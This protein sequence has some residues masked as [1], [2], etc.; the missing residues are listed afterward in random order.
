VKA[1]IW[2]HGRVCRILVYDA[3]GRLVASNDDWNNIASGQAAVNEAYPEAFQCVY[4]DDT[5]ALDREWDQVTKG[6][7]DAVT[8][9]SR[10]RDGFSEHACG[11][12]LR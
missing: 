10:E 4:R 1:K 9:P 7:T 8:T 3:E 2:I 5:A 11:N 12:P 6:S